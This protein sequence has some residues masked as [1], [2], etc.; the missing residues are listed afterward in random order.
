MSESFAVDVSTEAQERR[1]RIAKTIV[2]SIACVVGI[3]LL[4]AL[5]FGVYNYT[6]DRPAKELFSRDTRDTGR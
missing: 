2:L 6:T 3:T 1:I 5:V 4:T